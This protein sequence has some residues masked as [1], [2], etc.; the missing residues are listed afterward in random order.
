MGSP[1][2]F[3]LVT[4]RWMPW[5]SAATLILL[6]TGLVWGMGFAPEDVRQGNSFRIIY[7]HV[8][9]AFLALAGYF[10]MASAGAVGL[11]WK[12]KLSYMVMKCAAPIGA[13][14]TFVALFTGA[15]WGKPTWGS[16]WVWDA[17]VTSMLILF[18][19]YVGVM[20][21]RNA[22]HSQEAGNKAS[23][24][25]AL[26]GTVN[27]PIIYKSVDWWF[28]LHQPSTIKLTSAPTM[29]PD[30][31][32]PLLVMILGFYCFYALALLLSVRVEILKRER[33]TAWVRE[34]VGEHLTLNDSGLR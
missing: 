10:L 25:L 8:P 11:I 34:I 26:V 14:I 30:M 17:R 4:S 13:A 15:V 20:A 6:V 24:V 16:Y 33:K 12:M 28:T 21:L 3:Y 27:I 22:F 23:A 1:R 18:F 2:W 31:F 29:H 9:A 32:Q 19:L 5:L 7:L